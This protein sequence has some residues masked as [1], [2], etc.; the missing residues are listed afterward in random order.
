[1]KR[2]LLAVALFGC[3]SSKREQP[4][5]V[6]V[7]VADAA[8][9]VV[10]DAAPVVVAPDADPYAGYPERL[11]RPTT[12]CTLEGAWSHQPRG[13]AFTAGGKPYADIF[14]VKHARAHF[15][16]GV[17]VELETESM[18]LAGFTDAKQIALHAGKPFTVADYAAPGPKI[19]L[20][21]TGAHDDKLA[22]V[23]AVS[24]SR[25]RTDVDSPRSRRPGA[26]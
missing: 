22:G 21:Y 24:S 1:M 10:V 9:A 4:P 26:A 19:T 3:G 16:D 13:L 23:P 18:R 12:P 6:P 2:W 14:Q 7:V 25:A 5:A 17:F 11:A 8:P 20:R 15:G